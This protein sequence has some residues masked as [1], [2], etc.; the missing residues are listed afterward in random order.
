MAKIHWKEEEC[1]QAK[2]KWPSLL[3]KATFRKR[4]PPSIQFLQKNLIPRQP[5][6]QHMVGELTWL[7]ASTWI[8]LNISP[9]SWNS[10]VAKLHIYSEVGEQ[11]VYRGLKRHGSWVEGRSPSLFLDLSRALVDYKCTILNDQSMLTGLE[12]Q[13]EKSIPLEPSKC[14]CGG[15]KKGESLALMQATN[16]AR[17]HRHWW[18]HMI[19]ECE[20][21]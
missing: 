16:W 2:K 5:A 7:S 11:I 13:K 4:E 19:N 12:Q 15:E 8:V 17:K 1:T 20:E 10:M 21:D 18:V 14:W 9:G 6:E 3:I